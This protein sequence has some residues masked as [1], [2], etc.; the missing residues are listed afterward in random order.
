MSYKALVT[1]AGHPL[2]DP[3]TYNSTT[4]TLVDS[5]RNVQGKMIGSVIRENVAK[6]ELTWSYIDAK[7]WADISAL[8][9]STRG[10]A[11]IN[12][13]EFFNQDTNDWETRKLYVSDR[14]NNGAFIRDKNT[15]KIRGWLGARLALIEV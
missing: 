1:V 3:S 10:G 12:Q 7:T 5:A 11:F 9:D 13:V 6:V 4:S 8:F 14:T 15:G 2:P